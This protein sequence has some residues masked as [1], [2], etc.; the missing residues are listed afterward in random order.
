[1]R[2]ENWNTLVCIEDYKPDF[3]MHVS[4]HD[5]TV[6]MSIREARILFGDSE[7]TEA[8]RALENME[9]FKK[10]NGLPNLSKYERSQVRGGCKN[11]YLN[12]HMYLISDEEGH[13][14]ITLYDM[15]IPRRPKLDDIIE[16]HIGSNGRRESK[17]AKH[18]IEYNLE[19]LRSGDLVRTKFGG[20]CPFGLKGRLNDKCIECAHFEN[21]NEHNKTIICA[22]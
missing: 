18:V 13:R 3:F 4:F 20:T 16:L 1:M 11:L 6:K 19:K 2:D 7:P 14:A 15:R 22:R 10:V 8:D 12:Y 5:D 21:I 17:I 9:E